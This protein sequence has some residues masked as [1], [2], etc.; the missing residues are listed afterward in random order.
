VIVFKLIVAVRKNRIDWKQPVCGKRIDGYNPREFQGKCRID[1]QI[2]GIQSKMRSLPSKERHHGMSR[3][4][5]LRPEQ[6]V[7]A[8][9]SHTKITVGQ[10]LSLLFKVS[11]PE[12]NRLEAFPWKACRLQLRGS[13]GFTPSS[14]LSTF[15]KII[16]LR[17]RSGMAEKCLFPP[18]CLAK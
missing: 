15:R 13:D 10:W 17:Y 2:H 7:C 8:F 4:P 9:F 5:D 3:Y 11:I 12:E 6:L 18:C 16:S 1:D 14:L